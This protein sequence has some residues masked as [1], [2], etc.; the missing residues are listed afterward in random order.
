MTEHTATENKNAPAGGL[1]ALARLKTW[2]VDAMERHHQRVVSLR[3]YPSTQLDNV[4]PTTRPDDSSGDRDSRA[5]AA[6]SEALANT[7]KDIGHRVS[8]LRRVAD[9]FRAVYAEHDA[10]LIALRV[11]GRKRG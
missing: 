11:Y 9:W 1:S 6:D 8:P 10:N 2:I 7:E 3:V 4:Y 5:A